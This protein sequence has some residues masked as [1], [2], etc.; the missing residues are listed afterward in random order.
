MY[1]FAMETTLGRIMPCDA[2]CLRSY[3][4]HW[5]PRLIQKSIL[6]LICKWEYQK[7]KKQAIAVLMDVEQSMPLAVAELI[8]DAEMESPLEHLQDDRWLQLWYRE[9]V[10]F[11]CV[12]LWDRW[13][14]QPQY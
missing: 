13:Q 2:N 8:A 12:S 14:F 5:R 11:V 1:M 7:R 4:R 10:L 9:N 6:P 3:L